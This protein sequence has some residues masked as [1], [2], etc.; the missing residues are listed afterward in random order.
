MVKSQLKTGN[1][2][3]KLTGILCVYDGLQRM[4]VV[5]ECLA[6]GGVIV[7]DE[8][9]LAQLRVTDDVTRCDVHRRL[10]ET[11]SGRLHVVP[12]RGRGL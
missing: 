9:T 3:S 10:V 7:D 1:S 2:K 5:D 11:S 8:R 4:T 6:A 12:S